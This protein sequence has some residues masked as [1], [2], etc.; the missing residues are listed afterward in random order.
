MAKARCVRANTPVDVRRVMEG[1]PQAAGDL[2]LVDQQRLDR[3]DAIADLGGVE[4]ARD[5]DVG[6][7]GS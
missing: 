2:A 5:G 7:H 6:G 4:R 1:G 3:R